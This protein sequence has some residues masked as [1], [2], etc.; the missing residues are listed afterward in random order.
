M[1]LRPAL[2]L[3]LLLGPT[4]LLTGLTTAKAQQAGKVW[5]MG[6]LGVGP[7]DATAGFDVFREGLRA[8]GYVEGQNLHIER[9]FAQNN[10]DA[11][12]ALAAELTQL[13][14]AVI[15]AGDSQALRS[16]WET[17]KTIP[18]VMTVSA[19]PVGA[20]FVA[21][22]SRP[23]GNV[24]GLTNVSP[25]L[26]GKRLELLKEVVPKLTRVAIIGQARHP[27]WKELAE[28]ARTLGVRLQILKVEH[29]DEFERAFELSV[30]ERAGGL[31]VLPSPVTNFYSRRLIALAENHRL[32][33]MYP[34]RQYVEAGGLMAYG[35]NVLAMYRHAA[36]Y[37][38]KILKGAKPADL[39]V[40]QPTKFEFV[41]NLKTAKALGLTIPPSLLLRADQVIE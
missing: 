37:V 34:L 9:R 36:T 22:L 12:P 27:D 10:L 16:A 5:R 4:L 3:A 17:T 25:Q 14:V 26:A 32:P 40:E 1:W 18:I 23:G 11:L 41:I 28:A 21:S 20:G 29:R 13:K 33:A 31:I 24:T 6:W 30:M 39:P 8:L 7:A 35:P 2:L 15:V 38:D 19:D